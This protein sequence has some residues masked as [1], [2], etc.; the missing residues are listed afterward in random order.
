[1]EPYEIATTNVDS[2]LGRWEHAAWQPRAGDPLAGIVE[3]IWYFD[4]ATAQPLEL[5]LPDGTLEIVVQMDA[6]YRPPGSDT[7][8][9]AVSFEGLHLKAFAVEAPGTRCRVLGIRLDAA[10]AQAVLAEPPRVATDLSLDL[11]DV[12]GRAATELG[13]RC[14]GTRGAVD[15]VCLAAAWTAERARRGTLP[16]ACVRWLA[17]HI[18][19]TRGAAP[20][21]A[22]C[23]QTTRDPSR[24]ARAFREGIGVTPKRFARVLRFHHAAE[25]L[26]AGASLA[27]AAAGA[28]YYN[29]PHFTSEFREHAGFTPAAFVAATRYPDT[30]SLARS[31]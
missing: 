23:A 3:R 13:E 19:R 9:P 15:A 28:R 7:P 18:V 16:D 25:L 26:A 31:A 11:A 24:L 2:E 27:D 1:M 14:H 21:A 4:G 22:L 30:L 20:I 10:G 17:E 6:R 12:V 29:Q 8:F 5:R